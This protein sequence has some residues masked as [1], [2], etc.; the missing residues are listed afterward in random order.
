MVKAGERYRHFKGGE[1][2]VVAV[3]RDCE[4]VDKEV[5]VYRALY[6]TEDFPFGQIWTRSLE[7]FVGFKEKDVEKI[8]RF[9]LIE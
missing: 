7:D 9:S 5:V 3:A 4:D 8:K 1:Y 6:A 2:E